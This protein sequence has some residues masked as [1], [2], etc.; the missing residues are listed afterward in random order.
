MILCYATCKYGGD[1][2]YNICKH[3]KHCNIPSYGGID[4]FYVT[5]CALK[6]KPE[7]EES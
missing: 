6:E 5:G 1:N 4:R 2:Y 3:P 7:S